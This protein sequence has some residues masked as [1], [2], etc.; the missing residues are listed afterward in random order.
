[1][2]AA[3]VAL[4][5]QEPAGPV[6]RDDRRR[7]DRERREGLDPDLAACARPATAGER[8]RRGVRAGE[9]VGQDPAGSRGVALCA[10]ANA[11]DPET[12]AAAATAATLVVSVRNRS[13]GVQV[14]AA[15]AAA[16]A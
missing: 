4:R 10:R 16:R 12:A 2:H 11:G 5:R 1:C 6:E 7:R 13:R 9:T 8:L 15:A 14:V 3:D